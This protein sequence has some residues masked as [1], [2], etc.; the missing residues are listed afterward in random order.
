MD[1]LLTGVFAVIL[2]YYTYKLGKKKSDSEIKKNLIDA[3]KS[4]VEIMKLETDTKLAQVELFDKLNNVLTEQNQKLL[5][6][7]KV[8]IKQNEKLILHLESVEHR[9]VV[10]EELLEN[11]QCLEA[12]KCINRIK[13]KK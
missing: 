5:T 2:A 7:N 4:R 3:E 11:S 10:L 9:V 13:L 8:L 1:V 6:S 12:P